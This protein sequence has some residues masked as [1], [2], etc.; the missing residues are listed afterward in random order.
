M[1]EKYRSARL[2]TIYKVHQEREMK[3]QREFSYVQ[4]DESQEEGY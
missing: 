4:E 1:D 3:A 2:A